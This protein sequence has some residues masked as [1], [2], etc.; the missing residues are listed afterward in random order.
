PRQRAFGG[1]P[2]TFDGVPNPV[3]LPLIFEEA[4]MNYGFYD[5]VGRFDVLRRLRSGGVPDLSYWYAA[6]GADIELGYLPKV[7]SFPNL[8]QC[9]KI[10]QQDCKAFLV[11]SLRQNTSEG[12]Q[13]TV[14]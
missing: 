6:L 1:A 9:E 14:T 3:R 7:S 13:V 12:Q 10:Q 5:H 8:M 2:N 11:L 4:V